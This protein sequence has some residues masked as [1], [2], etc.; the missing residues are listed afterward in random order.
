MTRRPGQ[1][2]GVVGLVIGTLAAYAKPGDTYRFYEINPAVVRLAQQ[3]FRFLS[4]AAGANVSTATGDGRLLLEREA[5]GEYEVLA[6]DAFSG[7]SI[8]VHL[9]SR[10][11]FV[12]YA[13][14]LRPG[15]V[16]ALHVSNTLLNLAPVAEALAAAAAKDSRHIHA[17]ED[18]ALARAE[19]DWVLV[20]DAFP[21]GAPGQPRGAAAGRTPVWT[22]DHSHL[23]AALK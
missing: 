2:V 14:H 6:V 22:D 13:R 19:S 23:L 21:N 12:V 11:A 15:G 20:A 16:L 8:R 3:Y 18:D 4:G 10:E 17:T 1:R 7:D 5:P 9:L